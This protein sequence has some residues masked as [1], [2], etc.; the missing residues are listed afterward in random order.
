MIKS[1]VLSIL[2][3]FSDEELKKFEDFLNSP[4]HNKN[5]KVVN[6]FTVL[7]R[8]HPAYENINLN[9]EQIF[10]QLYGNVKYVEVN[11][12]NLLSDLNIL[13]EDFIRYINFSKSDYYEKILI[14]EFH[15]RD[16][17]EELERKVMQFEKK[18]EMNDLKDERYYE[19]KIFLYG[20]KSFMGSDKILLES[21]RPDEIK[22]KIIFF[23]ITLMESFFQ[24]I[25]E[26]QRAKI[27]HDFSFLKHSLEY[28]K[29]RKNE[30]QDSP[31][32][33]IY[34]YIAL[35]FFDE[36]D[37]N[38][39]KKVKQYFRLHYSSFDKLD[40]KNIYSMMQTYCLKKK[41][42]GN[43]FYDRELLNI[44]MEMIKFDIVTYKHKGFISLNIYRN[45]VIHCV[46]HKETDILKNF[47]LKYKNL[48]HPESRKSIVAYSNAHLNYVQKNYETALELCHKIDFSVL[49]VTTQ[50][51]LYFKNDTKTLIAKCLY[52][53]GSFE[54][55]ISGIDAHRHF[56]N[57]SRLIK[58]EMKKKYII[59]LNTLTE[60][61]RIRLKYDPYK[62][63]R[64]RQKL[65][66]LKDIPSKE[67]LIEKVEEMS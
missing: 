54:N 23:L 25:I 36:N 48:I 51:N 21:H 7:K 61:I 17:N 5:T 43:G 56:L 15:K 27:V 52:E 1:K 67:W 45:I 40:K 6:L 4:F 35:S 3:T 63:T 10:R 60:L 13:T 46:N 9:K 34:Y 32:L 50:D 31:I 18:I 49:L 64:L 29:I 38:N 59:F 58:D 62:V 39:Y 16:I 28:V 44:L 41:N 8:Y 65:K 37:E 30:F 11:I 42:Q 66:N 33:Q 22:S 19:D 26:E 24:L 57:N 14:E 20:M 55:I 53:L 2:K 12:R 47:I